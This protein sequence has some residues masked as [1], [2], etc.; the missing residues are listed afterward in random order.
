MMAKAVWSGTAPGGLVF[1]TQATILMACA[2]IK[3]QQFAFRQAL[4]QQKP[5]LA[6][7]NHY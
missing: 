6:A 2:N 3:V 4:S 7:V 5:P 1:L